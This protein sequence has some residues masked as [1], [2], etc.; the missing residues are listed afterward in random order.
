LT[1]CR[2]C[3][4]SHRNHSS[5]FA[6]IPSRDDPVQ[7]RRKKIPKLGKQSESESGR[8]PMKSIL[9]ALAL[10]GIL[11]LGAAAAQAQVRF[12]VRAGVP[13]PAV[14]AAIPP[15][16]GVGYVWT[17]GY[18]A[19]GMWVPGQWVYQGYDYGYDRAYVGVYA[20]RDFDH[21]YYDRD[22]RRGHD[23]DSYRGHEGFRDRH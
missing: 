15:A 11:G 20:H 3:A 18:Y 10:T 6:F 1:G 7:Q 17:P 21:G 4:V 5:N 19:E 16:P 22:S 14:V 8:S 13:V 9:R 2:F 23:R 12:A